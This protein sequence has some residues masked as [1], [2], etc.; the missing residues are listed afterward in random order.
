MYKQMGTPVYPRSEEHLLRLIRPWQVQGEGI[1]PLTA[2]A[3]QQLGQSIQIEVT[4]EYV[5]MFGAILV[6]P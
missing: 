1:Q 6:K 3:E 5:N 2:F 4:H